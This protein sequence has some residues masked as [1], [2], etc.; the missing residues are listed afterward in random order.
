VRGAALCRDNSIGTR[1]TGGEAIR[2]YT[3]LKSMVFKLGGNR[4]DVLQVGAVHHHGSVLICS[5]YREAG[6]FLPASL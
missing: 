3:D 6:K 1:H 4:A 5:A 2:N